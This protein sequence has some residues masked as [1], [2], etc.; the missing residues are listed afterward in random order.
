ALTSSVPPLELAARIARQRPVALASADRLIE[1]YLQESFGGR[2]LSDE[3]R[4]ELKQVLRE[5]LRSL[6]RREADRQADS[7]QGQVGDHTGQ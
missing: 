1:L 3:E 2:E 7:A 6:S 4:R 5:A